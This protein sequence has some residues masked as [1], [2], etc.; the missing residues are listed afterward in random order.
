MEDFYVLLGLQKN[1]TAQ[2]IKKAYRA[3][4]REFHPD[5]NSG[6]LEME[7]KFKAISVAYEILSD[8]EKREIY[9][10]YGVDGF[11]GGNA[12]SGFSNAQS[13]GALDF[14]KI[15]IHNLMI[16]KYKLVSI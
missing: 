16:F 1:A 3:K 4:A 12:G 11:R 8:P 6:D 10:R 9:D 13:G 7:E 5:A 15:K 2:E 14:R